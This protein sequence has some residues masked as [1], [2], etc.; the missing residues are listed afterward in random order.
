MDIEY[1]TCVSILDNV[2]AYD[3]E[4]KTAIF[5]ACP[6]HL[7]LDLGMHYRN[8]EWCQYALDT[9]TGSKHLRTAYDRE[10]ENYH[11]LAVIMDD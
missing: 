5:K 8:K 3:P 10:Q 4:I 1:K 6:T 9:D 11:T 2:D 7:L